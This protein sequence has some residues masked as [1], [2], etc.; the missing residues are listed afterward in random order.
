[1]K[2]EDVDA[3]I[4]AWDDRLR[5]IDENLLALESSDTYEMLKASGRARALEG[6]TEISGQQAL[7][8]VTEIFEARQALGTWFDRLKAA[9]ANVSF[10]NREAQLAQLLVLLEGEVIELAT[11][12]VPLAQ[13]GLLD[14]AQHK[15]RSKSGDLV[16]HMAQ[17]FARARDILSRTER[18]WKE[19]EKLLETASKRVTELDG[20]GLAAGPART[21]LETLKREVERISTQIAGNPSSCFQALSTWVV[22]RLEALGQQ[23]ERERQSLAKA[24][25]MLDEA[26]QRLASLSALESQVKTTI[27][28]TSQRFKHAAVT[29]D[30]TIVSQYGTWLEKLASTLEMGRVSAVEVGVK[31]FLE[32]CAKSSEQCNQQIAICSRCEQQ[33]DELVGR[34]RARRAQSTALARRGKNISTLETLMSQAETALA[35][36]PCELALASK[37]V[38]A[39][40]AG[41][42]TV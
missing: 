36:V 7:D 26:R 4:A 30:A 13:R 6:A 35:A 33:F 19:S 16:D 38:E 31:R 29:L 22:P 24:R 32:D 12:D 3:A 15:S 2:L 11:A 41:F 28:K 39:V 14:D 27:A 5:R 8:A 21:E 20:E 23:L 25:A 42:S 9:R 37:L 18:V 1:M 10:W 17:L 34:L 40:D